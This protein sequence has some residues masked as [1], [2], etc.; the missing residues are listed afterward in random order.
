MN[1]TLHIRAEAEPI[2]DAAERAA[3]ATGVS[4]SAFVTLALAE[5]VARHMRQDMER[6]DAKLAELEN[7]VEKLARRVENEDR[8]SGQLAKLAELAARLDRIEAKLT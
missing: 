8:A 1:K 6:R 3:T 4:L 7:E 5:A 2:W